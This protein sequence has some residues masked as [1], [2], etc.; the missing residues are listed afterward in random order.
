LRKFC[1]RKMSVC[2]VIVDLSCARKH[3]G[4]E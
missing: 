1:T 3:L 2:P 4:M